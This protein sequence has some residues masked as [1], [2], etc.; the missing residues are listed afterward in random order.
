[1]RFFQLRI[2]EIRELLRN[3]DKLP[4]PLH[5][6]VFPYDLTDASDEQIWF[7]P[8]IPPHEPQ[9]AILN[10]SQKA[11]SIFECVHAR[12]DW[13]FPNIP[14]KQF[15]PDEKIVKRLRNRR[16]L[17]DELDVDMA[18]LQAHIANGWVSFQPGIV[19]NGRGYICERCGNCDRK[20]FATFPCFRC[21]RECV[22]CRSCVVMGKVT[23]CSPL[24]LWNDSHVKRA[25]EDNP[26]HVLAWDGTLSYFQQKASDKICEAIT[27]F[28]S[29]NLEVDQFLVWAV[30]GAGKTEMLFHGIELALRMGLSVL[31]ATPRTDVVLELEPRLKEA[32]PEVVI[33]AFYGGAEDRFAQGDLVISTTHQ[34]LRFY[35]AF[36]LVIIDE[37]DAFPYTVDEKLRWAVQNSKKEKAL[38]IF[39]TATPD[40]KM[41]RDAERGKILSAKVA[42]RYHRHPL[43]VPRNI[44]I[45]EWKNRLSKGKLP[46]KIIA[47]LEKH[48]EAEKQ[49]FLF[50]PT[51]RVMKEVVAILS[52]TLSVVVAGVHAEDE[53]RREK[54]MR[55]RKGDIRVL[56]TTTILERGVTV[57]GVQVGVLGAEDYIFTEAAL[58]QIAGRVG[59][60]PEEPDGDVVFFHYGKT[61]EMV[62]AIRHIREMNDLGEKELV[63]ERLADVAK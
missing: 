15:V 58:V 56:V 24:F 62:K 45:G 19:A 39:V 30:C 61:T 42:R 9:H 18:T 28:Y 48:V 14:N 35:Q 25:P 20:L 16:L 51:V 17:L 46:K 47:W 50:V 2:K 53:E 55:F 33:H 21:K 8:E 36:D 37:V 13:F 38:T 29:G 63:E 7:I 49:I 12:H 60:S 41:K 10:V 5:K 11:M 34:L 57:K 59:R 27:D 3:H 52:K 31:I 43:P 1:M 23:S 26:K 44:W 54:V 4:S 32:F 6:Q 40:E 22:Y